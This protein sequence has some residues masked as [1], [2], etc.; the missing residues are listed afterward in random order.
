MPIIR[1]D[2]NE[3]RYNS[4]LL[5]EKNGNPNYYEQLIRNT[6]LFFYG[7]GK[8]DL[9]DEMQIIIEE[10]LENRLGRKYNH[11]LFIYKNFRQLK[12]FT[13]PVNKPFEKIHKY[14][15]K[16]WLD[17]VEEWILRKVSEQEKHIRY[18]TTAKQWV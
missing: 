5:L 14:E 11:I 15:I 18:T 17:E 12:S 8:P 3:M 2:N 9:V 10:K 4:I 16:I 13:R 7:L 6:K 1:R